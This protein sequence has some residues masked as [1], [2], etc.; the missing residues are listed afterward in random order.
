MY[1]RRYQEKTIYIL[2]LLIVAFV[3]G[4]WF[5]VI[6]FASGKLARYS[7][8]VFEMFHFIEDGKA[9]EAYMWELDY[10]R[11]CVH[12]GFLTS[13]F[14]LFGFVSKYYKF[15][16]YEYSFLFPIILIVISAFLTPFSFLYF[17]FNL[18]GPNV[19]SLSIFLASFISIICYT[20]SAIILFYYKTKYRN[21]DFDL[22]AIFDKNDNVLGIFRYKDF[23]G[24][25]IYNIDKANIFFED[26]NGEYIIYVDNKNIK[27]I[28]ETFLFKLAYLRY[29]LDKVVIKL[30]NKEFDY[31]ENAT[32]YANKFVEEYFDRRKNNK[33]RNNS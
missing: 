23:D 25:I 19:M 22:K 30:S 11:V 33:N 32:V 4:V 13:L 2:I 10:F 8:Q 31:H 21:Y 1:K 26:N 15:K 20:T 18:L 14:S 12:V 9:T 28:E 16:T 5:E 3:M 29:Y 7:Y 27:K 6:E 17:I 24:M